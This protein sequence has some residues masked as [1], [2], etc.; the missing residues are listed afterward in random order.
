MSIHKKIFLLV[1]ATALLPAVVLTLIG[2]WLLSSTVDSAS[3]RQAT[4]SQLAVQQQ[5]ATFERMQTSLADAVGRG[6]LWG[7]A[8]LEEDMTTIRTLSMAVAGNPLIDL[9]TVCTADGTVLVR[10]HSDQAGDKLGQKYLTVHAPLVTK[11]RVS[12]LEMVN[13]SLLVLS[14]G[15][16]IFSGEKLAGVAVFATILSDNYLLE[17]IKTTQGVEFSIF[18]EDTRVST[19]LDAT[20]GNSIAGTKVTDQTILNAVL[21]R[22][23][24]VATQHSIAGKNFDTIYWPWRDIAGNTK[25]M[26]LVAVSR[27]EAATMLWR[28]IVMYSTVVLAITLIMVLFGFVVSRAIAIPIKKITEHAQAVAGGDLEHSFSLTSK[29]EVGLLAKSLSLMIGN[30]KE[31]NQNLHRQVE[32]QVLEVKHQEDLLQTV[33]DVASVLLVSDIAEFDRTLWE[34]MG[35]LAKSADIDRVRIWK[36]FERDGKLYCTQIDE[37]S[38]NVPRLQGTP[39]ATERAYDDIVPGWKELLSSG[40]NVTGIVSNLSAEEQ[41]QLKPQGVRSLLV[42][43]ALLQNNFWGF[44][45][46]DDCRKERVFTEKEESVLRSGGLLIANALLRN[47]MT[48]ELIQA[49]NDALSSARAKS[50]FLANM[51][52]EIRTPINAIT[53]MA[54]IARNSDE[55]EKIYSCLDKVNAA[56]RQLL[57]IINDILDISKIEA[58]KMEF[59]VEPFVLETTI[60]NIQSIIGVQSA[61]K[62]QALHVHVSDNLPKVVVGDEMRLSQILLNLLSNAVKF[63][64]DAGEI[65]LSLKLLHTHDYVHTLEAQV[66]DNGIGMSEEQQAKVFNNFEQADKGT[67]KRFGGTGL[68][69]AISKRIA[70][71]MNGGILLES[72]LEKGSCF[73]VHFCLQSGNE[74]MLIQTSPYEMYT[75]GFAQ[76]TAL[77]VEDI[78]INQEIVQSLLEDSGITVVCV[79]NGQEAVDAFLANPQRYDIIFMD[80]QMPVMDGYD[81]TRKIRSSGVPAAETVPILAMTANAFAE[82]AVA[83]RAAGMNDHISKPIEINLLLHKIAQLVS[84]TE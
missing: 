19:T 7:N 62:R 12:G 13:S 82:D 28:S 26:F 18:Y 58:N 56:S 57:G 35:M 38:E 44:V 3:K 5:L 20:G 1:M 78:V 54:T 36:N 51:S 76:Y 16:P 32:E 72:E 46:Y 9:V 65:S 74:E 81:A 6:D 34:C 4:V 84:K 53:G 48:K 50:N 15:V 47:V 21:D 71:L 61:K 40:R 33:T 83:C 64:P 41:K 23:E 10:G 45:G 55:L 75:D 22:E 73:T 11:R 63:T 43:P 37:W 80:I 60:K 52:H 29:D 27:E 17:N 77:L 25:G 67:S 59:A 8:I 30:L 42:V 39:I 31:N 2:S 49:S 14:T 70:E 24:T 68:G 69:L 66:R 79:N